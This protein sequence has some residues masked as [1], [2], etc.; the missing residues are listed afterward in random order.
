MACSPPRAGRQDWEPRRDFPFQGGIEAP[1]SACQ[2]ARG[3]Y[4]TGRGRAP[5]PFLGCAPGRQLD[6]GGRPRSWV[7][8]ARLC[9]LL[10]LFVAVCC[11]L[12]SSVG[13]KTKQWMKHER[14]PQSSCSCLAFSDASLAKLAK[15]DFDT[16]KDFSTMLRMTCLAASR[17]V[18]SQV[19][20][21][22][23]CSVTEAV[24]SWNQSQK[25]SRSI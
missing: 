20:A 25:I 10:L 17:L 24:W 7:R 22:I 23:S 19:S 12:R 13:N 4:C 6:R 14:K 8:V 9:V 5:H 15:V 11:H 2:G 18:R 16:A 3:P 21:L 1:P